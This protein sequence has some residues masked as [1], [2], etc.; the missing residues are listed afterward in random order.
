MHPSGLFYVGRFDAAVPLFERKHVAPL[1]LPPGF[2]WET[3]RCLMRVL[4]AL[5]DQCGAQVQ[6]I[7][8]HSD[9]YLGSSVLELSEPLKT[10]DCVIT[11]RLLEVAGSI[12]IQFES[13]IFDVARDLHRRRN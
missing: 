5:R 12:K 6:I 3:V 10:I 4:T 11:K 13:A 7:D 9:T 8:V 2:V 1:E